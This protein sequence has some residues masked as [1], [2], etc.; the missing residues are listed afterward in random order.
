[1]SNPLPSQSG[2]HTQASST[3]VPSGYLEGAVEHARARATML[4][5]LCV[6]FAEAATI[7]QHLGA[8][9]ANEAIAGFAQRVR[10][11]SRRGDHIGRLRDDTLV[12][13]AECMDTPF[14]ARRLADRVLGVLASPLELGQA[15]VCAG[16][17]IGIATGSGSE[18]NSDRLLQRARLAVREA[19]RE[20]RCRLAESM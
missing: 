19:G 5:V 17:R 11:C 3:D 8:H 20:G 9:A 12:L 6:E 10:G 14:A 13:I 4:A 2:I 16:A 18:L 7:R 1:M 15:K